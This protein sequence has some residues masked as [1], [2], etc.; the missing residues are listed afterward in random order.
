MASELVANIGK[1]KRYLILILAILVLASGAMAGC[2]KTLTPTQVYLD[3]A[4]PILK[5]NDETVKAVTE[6]I[7]AINATVPEPSIE[8]AG[9]S[10]L[11]ATQKS[12]EGQAKYNKPTRLPVS[13]SK[14][15]TEELVRELTAPRN[16]N[17]E[18]LVFPTGMKEA[19]NTANRTLS[20]STQQVGAQ[21]LDW[22]TL[23]PT[24]ATEDYHNLVAQAL[25]T[26]QDAWNKLN[27]YYASFLSIGSGDEKE[28]DRA[29]ILLLE[30]RVTLLE[31]KSQ[32]LEIKLAE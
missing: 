24:P 20:E 18:F 32:L 30:A 7:K 16:P 13:I 19:L 11:T 27:S 25:Q 8:K 3:Q 22:R 28:L 31:A 9:E 29:N 21:L 15:T 5:R 23:N 4:S 6:A 2:S 17:P 12:L 26:Q 14:L 1:M 10:N